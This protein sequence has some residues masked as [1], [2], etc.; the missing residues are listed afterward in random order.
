MACSN[1]DGFDDVMLMVMIVVMLMIVVMMVVVTM[2]EVSRPSSSAAALVLH[3]NRAINVDCPHKM[4]LL[5]LQSPSVI[6][7]NQNDGGHD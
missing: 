5:I 7:R 2:L 4:F 6:F 1:D 3:P